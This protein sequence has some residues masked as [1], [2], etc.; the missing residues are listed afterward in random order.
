M[1]LNVLETLIDT[2]SIGQGPPARMTEGCDPVAGRYRFLR[3]LG[4]GGMGNVYLA[5]DLLLARQVAVKTVRPELSGNQEVRSRIKRECRMHAAIGVHPNIVTLYDTVE[6]NG[7]IYLVMEYFP[8]E[9]LAAK[10]AGPAGTPGLP[11]NQAL[12]VIRQ[13]L[14][15]LACIHARDIVHRDIKTSNILLQLLPD[16]H[17]LAKL[18]DF[19]IARADVETE[20]MTRLTSL[21]TQG[22]G[23]PVYM[24]PERIDP[25]TF[26][27]VSPASDLYA[28]GIILYELLAGQPPFTGTLTEIF[29]GHLMQQPDFDAVPVTIPA[30]LS[31]V[32]NKALAKKPADRY[33]DAQSF[34]EALAAGGE[35]EEKAETAL[36]RPVHVPEAT[37]LAVE[38][39]SFLPAGGNATVLDLASGRGRTLP[40]WHRKWVYPA[41]ALLLLLLAGLLLRAQFAGTPATSSAPA[42]DNAV[43]AEGPAAGNPADPPSVVSEQ[44]VEKNNSALETVENVRLQKSAEAKTAAERADSGV[45]SKQEWQIIENRS[46]KIH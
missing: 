2:C 31:A 20:A 21:G 1:M 36:A 19:G 39:E 27:E 11:L 14:R 35:A 33:Q 24:A 9:T 3:P 17:Y 34:L 16:G 40:P 44:A 4:E 45:A 25:Q 46:K 12:N 5:E 32:L 18:T 7:H 6:E 28:A 8:G 26:G 41:V 43:T 13:L 23:T 10:L 30:R 15:A 38:G 22:P 29:T 37:L 42:I